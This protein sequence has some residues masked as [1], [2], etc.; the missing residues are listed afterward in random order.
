MSDS[1]QKPDQNKIVT[2]KDI[3]NKL[4]IHSVESTDAANSGYVTDFGRKFLGYC[5]IDKTVMP[6]MNFCA[7]I[8]TRRECEFHGM[9]YCA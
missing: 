8:S 2:L 7:N 5:F 4:R 1:Y 6:P 9:F 3:A